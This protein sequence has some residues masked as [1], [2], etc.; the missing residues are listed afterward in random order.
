MET[1]SYGLEIELPVVTNE[2]KPWNGQAYIRSLQEIWNTKKYV[3]HVHDLNGKPIDLTREDNH[4]IITAGFDCV[5]SN[6]ELAIGPYASLQELQNT[7]IQTYNEVLESVEK[8]DAYVLN[9]SEAPNQ[10]TNIEQY[11]DFVLEKSFYTYLTKIRGHSHYIGTDAKA[12]ISPCTG[13]APQKA[14]SALNLILKLSPVFI[15]LYANSP[16]EEGYDTG[17]AENRLTIWAR[18]FATSVFSQD[19]LTT[20]APEGFFQSYYHYISWLY[21]RNIP[22]YALAK[23]KK[24]LYKSSNDL[25]V[26]K[27]NPDLI[28]YLRQKNWQGY[29][30]KNKQTYTITPHAKDIESQQSTQFLDARLRFSFGEN[31]PK[32]KKFIKMFDKTLKKDVNYFDDFF[33]DCLDYTYIENRAPGSQCPDNDLREEN[34]TDLHNIQKSVHSAISVL[35]AGVLRACDEIEDYLKEINYVCY[36]KQ[37]RELAIVKGLNGELENYSLHTISKDIISI[38]EKYL[39]IQEK[40]MLAYIYY[41]LDRKQCGADKARELAK[42]HKTHAGIDWQNLCWQ[43]KATVAPNDNNSINNQ[44]VVK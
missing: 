22:C 35:Q 39:N 5:Y 6:L 29:S 38:I 34:P 7:T 17:N 23:T 27:D 19:M 43:R 9:F 13:I 33:M 20:Y 21:N 40:K 31:P 8:H 1:V 36:Y 11:Q 32:V 24:G 42:K 16:Y 15:A 12:Q 25:V 28:T 10:N 30:V 3:S 18:E 2:T 41:L 26:I 44:G 37:L 4:A 14:I